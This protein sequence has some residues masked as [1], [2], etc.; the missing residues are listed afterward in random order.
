M[1]LKDIIN[2]IQD[3]YNNDYAHSKYNFEQPSK[4][5]YSGRRRG[6]PNASYALWKL[7]MPNVLGF[8]LGLAFSKVLGF[9]A[10][11]GY[12]IFG[13]IFAILLGMTD[14]VI[15]RKMDLVPALIRNAV[16]TTFMS[17]VLGIFF[18]SGN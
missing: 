3:E 12:L 8:V 11:S 4:Y 2:D 15:M 16:L 18:I 13:I 9:E 1:K 14:N 6:D 10:A 5:T 17:I 7:Y